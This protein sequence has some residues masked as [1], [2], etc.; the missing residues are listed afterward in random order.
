MLRTIQLYEQL[1]IFETSDDFASE[2]QGLYRDLQRAKANLTQQ[3]NNLLGRLHS[4]ITS[5]TTPTHTGFLDRLKNWWHNLWGSENKRNPY[6]WRNR[7]GALGRT[8]VEPTS[9]QEYR[10]LNDLA[11]SLTEAV[12]SSGPLLVTKILTNWGNQLRTAIDSHIDNMMDRVRS[13]MTSLGRRPVLTPTRGEQSPSRPAEQP[14]PARKEERPASDPLNPDPIKPTPSRVDDDDDDGSSGTTLPVDR[15]DDDDDDDDDDDGGSS[16]GGETSLP[17]APKPKG[18]ILSDDNL[19]HVRKVLKRHIGVSIEKLR[20]KS[21]DGVS[22][23]DRSIILAVHEPWFRANRILLNRRGNN[24]HAIRTKNKGKFPFRIPAVLR[25][26]DPRIDILKRYYPELYEWLESIHDPRYSRIERPN[27]DESEVRERIDRIIRRNKRDGSIED[28][29]EFDGDEGPSK[30]KPAEGKKKRTSSAMPD[31]EEKKR[32]SEKRKRF[33]SEM[34]ATAED[35][36]R[37]EHDEKAEPE[38]KKRRSRKKKKDDDDDVAEMIN[39]YSPKL[40]TINEILVDKLRL[41]REGKVIYDAVLL[42]TPTV[43]KLK[44]L[45][46]EQSKRIYDLS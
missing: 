21:V 40:R 43:A 20:A 35:R 32:P 8:D 5:T 10:M 24:Y 38:E 33:T 44:K 4:Q 3:V 36:E 7:L 17:E 6:Y 37:G 2:L 34:P 42:Q 29:D 13:M 12:S 39:N 30:K 19:E 31:E 11:A 16:G 46:R 26:N 23:D 28:G 18:D 25:K 45:L 27:E 41:Q 1:S 14:V 15:H 9:V 22:E